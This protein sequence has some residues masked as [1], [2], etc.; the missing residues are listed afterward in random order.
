MVAK[1]LS[2]YVVLAL[3]GLRAVQAGASAIWRLIRPPH[4]FID[5]VREIAP[6]MLDQPQARSLLSVGEEL[7]K[8]V[9]EDVLPGVVSSLLNSTLKRDGTSTN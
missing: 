9:F 4:R 8:G 6:L 3:A 7:G 5:G 2:L 1:L